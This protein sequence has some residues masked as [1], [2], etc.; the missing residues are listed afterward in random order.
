MAAR[1][2]GGARRLVP[3]LAQLRRA[4]WRH[5][6]CASR[7]CSGA[8]NVIAFSQCGHGHLRSPP[9]AAAPH[10]ALVLVVRSV[11]RARLDLLQ[12][13]APSAAAVGGSAADPET[14]AA[15]REQVV[16]VPRVGHGIRRQRLLSAAEPIVARPGRGRLR[17]A[18]GSPGSGRR[19]RRCRLAT[20]IIPCY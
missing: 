9:R 17:A 7:P 15:V 12:A 6:R 1:R 2:R 11:P 16:Q 10:W 8:D 14:Q 3:A 18:H 13:C 20:F 5:A 19:G 4:Q